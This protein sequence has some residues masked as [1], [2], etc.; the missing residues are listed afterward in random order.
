MI[1]HRDDGYVEIYCDDCKQEFSDDEI[2]LLRKK[3]WSDLCEPCYKKKG[4]TQ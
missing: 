4:D 1:K 2:I 3:V